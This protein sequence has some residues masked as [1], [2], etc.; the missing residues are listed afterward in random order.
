MKTT[1]DFLDAIKARHGLQ[2]D[3]ALAAK[4]GMTL[5]AISKY[6]N[7]KDPMGDSTAIKVAELLEIDPAIVTAAAHLER[8]KKD[9]EKAVWNSILEKLGGLAALVLL[10]IGGL[11][12]APPAQASAGQTAEQLALCQIDCGN[13]SRKQL[14]LSSVEVIMCPINEPILSGLASVGRSRLFAC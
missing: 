10:G 12:A 2:S 3:Y 4:L 14:Q 6:R 7:R 11:T 5:A 9:D 1:C 13:G 8:A